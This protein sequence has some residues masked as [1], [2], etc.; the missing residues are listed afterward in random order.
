[1]KL[2]KI[3][4]LRIRS[5]WLRPAV[6]RKIDEELRLQIEICMAENI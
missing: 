3:I 4:W 5:L 6:K 1:M 2:F